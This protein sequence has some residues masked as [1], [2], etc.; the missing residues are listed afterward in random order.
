MLVAPARKVK[1]ITAY[2]Q[3]QNEYE[4]EQQQEQERKIEEAERERDRAARISANGR[5]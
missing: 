1:R 5:R 2:L 4:Y 3:A